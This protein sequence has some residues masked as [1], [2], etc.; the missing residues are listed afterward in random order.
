[1]KTR[2]MEMGMRQGEMEIAE[3][4]KIREKKECTE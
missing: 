2:E 1:M 3:G 4:M